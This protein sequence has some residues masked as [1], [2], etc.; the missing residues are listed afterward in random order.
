MD[1][2]VSASVSGNY[3]DVA[4]ATMALACLKTR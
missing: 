2:T 3:N 4:L 1:D